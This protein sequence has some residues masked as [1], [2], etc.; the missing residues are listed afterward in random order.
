MSFCRNIKEQK[1]N[2]WGV[3]LYRDKKNAWL[4][5]IC[6]GLAANFNTPVWLVRLI[7]V[8]GLMIGGQVFVMLYIAGIFL[9]AP[10]GKRRSGKHKADHGERREH[11]YSHDTSA[12]LKDKVF[13]YGPS[14]SGR[15]AEIAERMRRVDE[16]LRRMES[17]VTSKKFQFDSELKR[18]G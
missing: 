16:S 1:R 7:A 13:N 12:T 17:Y 2:G 14:S 15:V 8:C 9:I 11:R 4:A 18:G 6:A 3:G 5:G 10:R